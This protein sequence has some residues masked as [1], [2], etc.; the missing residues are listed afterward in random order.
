MKYPVEKQRY[1][2]LKETCAQITKQYN[3]ENID[4]Q[5][6]YDLIQKKKSRLSSARRKAIVI[7][8]DMDSEMHKLAWE[9]GTTW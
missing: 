2:K 8:H 3:L 7:V 1:L 6:E 4:I 5:S 9:W